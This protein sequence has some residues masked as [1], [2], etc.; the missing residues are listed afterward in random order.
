M[1]TVEL[2][3]PDVTHAAFLRAGLTER[4]GKSNLRARGVRTR[5]E[6]DRAYMSG[7]YD[8]S[9]V[10][11]VLRK[12]AVR[13]MDLARRRCVD[14]GFVALGEMPWKM[15]ASS[16][17]AENGWP[18][19]VGDVMVIP[20]RALETRGDMDLMRLFVHE[21]VHVAQRKDPDGAWGLIGE[22]W[23]FAELSAE[24]ADEIRVLGEERIN[25]DT[26]GRIY[27]L[28]G[29]VCH[30]V[31]RGTPSTLA[32]ITLVPHSHHP[33]FLSSAHNHEHPYEIMAEL[34]ADEVMRYTSPAEDV[35]RD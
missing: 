15:T 21:A 5:E 3:P 20:M 6:Y 10:P 33:R 31:F 9:D 32:D 7:L 2:V 8:W 14:A 11:E 28:E 30:P 27:R 29:R 34:V 24:E 12:R 23:N 19:T 13:I 22:K 25:P 26:D 17:G 1:A 18:H 35:I 4:M 16:S